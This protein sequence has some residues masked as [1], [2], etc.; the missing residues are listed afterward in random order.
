[1][2]DWCYSEETPSLHF[3]C[4]E[5]LFTSSLSFPSTETSFP[6]IAVTWYATYPVD[7][8]RQHLESET[9]CFIN[10]KWATANKRHR[11]CVKS[12]RDHNFPRWNCSNEA[13]PNLQHFFKGSLFY[14]IIMFSLERIRFLIKSPNLSLCLY[15]FSRI[16]KMAIASLESSLTLQHS[17]RISV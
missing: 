11:D 10:Y 13:S 17:L 12:C 8:Q 4:P 16:L 9:S 2:R 15:Q 5:I 1:M 6:L 14:E 7:T 3:Q